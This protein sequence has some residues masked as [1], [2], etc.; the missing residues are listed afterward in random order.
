VLL[1]VAVFALGCVLGYLW[2]K[3]RAAIDLAHSQQPAQ[4]EERYVSSPGIGS[5]GS[6]P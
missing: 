4:S 3:P 5:I 2:G 6:G 1:V